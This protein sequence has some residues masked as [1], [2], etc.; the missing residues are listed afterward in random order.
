MLMKKYSDSTQSVYIPSANEE[1][2]KR[3]EQYIYSKGT[4]KQYH[5]NSRVLSTVFIYIRSIGDGL[6]SNAKALRRE[7]R[8]QDKVFTNTIHVY[9]CVK[10]TKTI[11]RFSFK[12]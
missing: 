6:E 3:F 2:H 8:K 9:L 10:E 7:E 5:L 4:S 1:K 12:A 11:W